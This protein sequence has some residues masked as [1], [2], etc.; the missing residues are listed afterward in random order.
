MANAGGSKPQFPLK[1]PGRAKV[2]KVVEA[3]AKGSQG[4]PIKFAIQELPEDRYDEAV[5]HMCKYFIADEPMCQCWNGIEDPVYVDFFRN[6]WKETLKE[7]L[8]VAAFVEDPN[9]GKPILAGMNVLILSCKDEDIDMS[10]TGKSQKAQQLMVVLMDMMKKA[11]I[12]E[13]YGVDRYMGA[14][15]LSVH[16]SYRGAALGGHILDVRN[17]VGREHNIPVTATAFTSPISQKLAARSGFEDL[18]SKDYDDMLDEQGN[19]I[20]PGIKSKEMK[21]MAKRLY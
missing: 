9:G 11:N 6:L 10:I 18:Y 13:K 14:I 3:K 7:G 1:P 5:E 15:G 2:W 17:A 12:Y 19:K 20:F 21:I 4:P 16:P 8:T